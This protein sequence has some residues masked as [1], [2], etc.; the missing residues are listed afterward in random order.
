MNLYKTT[1]AVIISS[2][3]TRFAYLVDSENLE[4]TISES[5]RGYLEALGYSE[6]YPNFD[7]IRIGNVHPFAI[8]LSQAVLGRTQSTNLFPS[9]TVA[10][11][12]TDET[13][14]VISDDYEALKFEAEHIAALEGYRLEKKIFISDPGWAMVKNK[15][16]EN[17]FIIGV[18]R[19]YR[20]THSLDLNIWTENK[21]VTGFLFDMMGHF[22]TQ[23]R[24]DLHN[25]FD[26]DLGSINGRRTGDINLD[27]GM[28]L[29]GGNVSIRV[30]MKHSAVLFDTSVGTI[31]SIDTTTLPEYFAIGGV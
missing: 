15:V 14:T 21:E 9:I 27:F 5:V 25:N 18:K 8:L 24:V 11:S 2:P 17:G 29:Y 23:R 26:I 4:T 1:N 7:N 31:A 20:T 28:L 13:E 10:D 12:S 6:L 19:I 16:T 3:N 22:V 30:N